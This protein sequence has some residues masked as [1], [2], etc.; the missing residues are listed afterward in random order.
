[1]DPR[2]LDG[3]RHP[4]HT[5]TPPPPPSPAACCW[6]QATERLEVPD[7][8][9]APPVAARGRRETPARSRRNLS[10]HLRLTFMA[11]HANEAPVG[12]NDHPDRNLPKPGDYLQFDCL[13][14]GGPLNRW[15]QVL[16][17]GHDFPGA[18]VSHFPRPGE[19]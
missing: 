17:R 14:P 5:H 13:P 10:R 9:V 15:S 2:S 6:V 8:A 16:T 1:M 3:A 11:P 19:A 18:Q 7:Q 12:Q 4:E